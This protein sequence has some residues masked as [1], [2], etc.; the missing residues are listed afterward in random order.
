LRRRRIWFQLAFVLA[1]VGLLAWRVNLGSALRTFGHVNYVWVVAALAVFTVS[2][3]VHAARWRILLGRIQGLPLSGLFGTYLVSNM[4]NN[5]MP[6]RTGDLVRIQ[7]PARR[8]NIARAELTAT[9]FVVETL[10]DVVT[11]AILLLAGLGLQ[12][13]PALRQSVLFT[14]AG[15]VALAVLLTALA[16]RI[17]LPEDLSQV[18]WGRL[19][20]DWLRR[21]VAELVPPFVDGL[22]AMRDPRIGARAITISFPAWLIEVVVFWL[23]GQAFDLDLGFGAYLVIMISANLIVSLPITPT[24]FGL[25]EVALQEVIALFGVDRSLAA[26]YAIGTHI[27]MSVWIVASGLVA[28]WLMNIRF[29]ELF[30][31]RN[32]ER[33]T[34]AV[35]LPG[36]GQT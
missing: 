31:L 16:A 20:P 25:Y 23:F 22:A 7:V 1:F 19:L 8:Y 24:S 3:F 32:G 33:R 12:D 5:L 26:G 9:V 17:R 2:K 30:Y 18:R 28:A 10:L 14:F 35:S 34:G 11:F 27:F 4:V 36:G 21:R 13:V 29:D 6:L 15:L